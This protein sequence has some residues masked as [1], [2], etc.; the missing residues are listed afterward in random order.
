VLKV[1]KL[2]LLL[3]MLAGY[4]NAQ[5]ITVGNDGT[6][7]VSSY[8]YCQLKYPDL[9]FGTINGACDY[10]FG[11]RTCGEYFYRSNDNYD[12]TFFV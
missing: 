9:S 1:Q 2:L 4:A 6:D 8:T 7:H 3:I 12:R 10:H 11:T 5:V